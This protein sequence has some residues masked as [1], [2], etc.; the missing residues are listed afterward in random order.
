MAKKK[1]LT[2]G[3]KF[4]KAAAE[5]RDAEGR[6]LTRE[7]LKTPEDHERERAIKQK[8][9]GWEDC[10]LCDGTGRDDD[11]D[12]CPHCSGAGQVFVRPDGSIDA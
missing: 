12:E 5:A 10:G 3:Q 2:K 1:R 4:A 6:Q 8:Y 9:G 11:D 7:L